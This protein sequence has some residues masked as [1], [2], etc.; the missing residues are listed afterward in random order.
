MGPRPDLASIRSPTNRSHGNRLGFV[1]PPAA[2]RPRAA[3]D[4]EVNIGR[5]QRVDEF[6]IGHEVGSRARTERSDRCFLSSE[7][8]RRDEPPAAA[9]Y[10]YLLVRKVCFFSS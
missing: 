1:R 10:S 3:H 8:G 6:V 5:R 7:R 9:G 2:R 4:P